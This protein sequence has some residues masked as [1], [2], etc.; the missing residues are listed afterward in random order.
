M[1]RQSVI[2]EEQQKLDRYLQKNGLK[3]SRGRKIVFEEVLQAHGHFA[4]EDLNKICQKNKRC[5]SRATVYRSLREFLEAGIIRETAFGEKHQHFEHV[6]DEQLHHHAR[7]IRCYGII[8][9]PC[10]GIAQE[11]QDVCRKNGFR[12]LGH[13]LHIYGICQKCQANMSKLKS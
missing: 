6:Y 8:E 10:K 5:V 4:A 9:F 11:Y 7:C 12:V 1:I 13:E 3:I 2:K